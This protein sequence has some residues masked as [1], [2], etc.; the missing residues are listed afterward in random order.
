MK[1]NNPTHAQLSFFHP[2]AER[3]STVPIMRC[4][5]GFF[6]LPIIGLII[7]AS[8]KAKLRKIAL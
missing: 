5:S 2:V 8:E 3:L 1:L 6:S 4:T 7:K